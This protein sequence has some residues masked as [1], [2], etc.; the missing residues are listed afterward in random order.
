MPVYE[1]TNEAGDDACILAITLEGISTP[2][3]WDFRNLCGENTIFCCCRFPAFLHIRS[4][5]PHKLIY[6]CLRSANGGPSQRH[7][8]G[9]SV[10]VR[11]LLTLVVVT[12]I[13]IMTDECYI[14]N[15]LKSKGDGK[16]KGLFF[17]L[18][19]SNKKEQINKM[20][21]KYERNNTMMAQCTYNDIY[22]QNMH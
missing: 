13:I 21:D 3:G 14:T 17:Y 6:N 18:K 20:Q 11:A 5:H 7:E 4:P 12:I 16:V 22:I 10:V 19:K 8:H 9:S 1:C 2:L 15:I